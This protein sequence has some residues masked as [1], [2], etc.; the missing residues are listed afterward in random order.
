MD[1]QKKANKSH[2]AARIVIEHAIGGMKIFDCF[3]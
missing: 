3:E 1:Q 2:A